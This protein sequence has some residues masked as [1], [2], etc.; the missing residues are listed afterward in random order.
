MENI[1]LKKVNANE[2]GQLQ[3]IAVQ[4]FVESYAALNT[5]ENINAYLE[6]SFSLEKLSAE[7]GDP[8]SDFYF[9]K[10][11]DA[12]IGYLK[13]NFGPAQTDLHDA[14]SVEI[15][16][17]YVLKEFQGKRIG[18]L[19][20]EETIKIAREINADYVWLGVW[21]RNTNAIRFYQRHGFE[22]FDMHTFVLGEEKQ[23]DLL[24]RLRLNV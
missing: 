12:V 9:A 5:E 2:A 21:E 1:V 3:T 24:M 14:K 22:T 6:N 15:E 18:K 20:L 16:R 13:L 8:N 4:T 11:K 17:I 19:F 7:L 10:M 23:T